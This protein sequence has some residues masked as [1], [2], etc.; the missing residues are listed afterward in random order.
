[1]TEK[2]ILKVAVKMQSL[3]AWLGEKKIQIDI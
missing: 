3:V 2:R 1:M